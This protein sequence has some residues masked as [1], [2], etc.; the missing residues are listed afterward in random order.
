MFIP[1]SPV[2]EEGIRRHEND[3]YLQG[4][5]GNDI[6][7][8]NVPLQQLAN[9]T[10]FLNRQVAMLKGRGGYLPANDFGTLV[11]T[12]QMLTNYA[13]AEIGITDQLM[14]FN[15][16]RVKNLFDGFVW[17][18]NNT[19]DSDPPVFEWVNDGPDIVSADLSVVNATMVDGFGRNLFEVLGVST[20]QEAMIELQ[21]RC[22]NNA[23]IDNSK[24][25][26][27]GDLMIGDYIDGLDLS[28]AAPHN[29]GDAPQAWNETYKN[30]RIVIAG[31]NTYKRVGDTGNGN[32][33]N[34]ILFTFRNNCFRSR[35][36]A[37][38][39][40]TGGYA[41]SELRT[42]LEGATGDGSGAF[43]VALKAQLGNVLYTIKKAHSKKSSYAWN[44][45]TVFI[46]SEI[47]IF[48]CPYWGDEGTYMQA[49]TSPV[50]PERVGYTTNVHFP[51]FQNGYEYRMRLWNGAR[52]WS[53]LSTP[54]AHSGAYFCGVSSS[55]YSSANGAS[56]SGGVAPAFCVA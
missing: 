11:P 36:N 48:G 21:R 27:F 34:H 38:N 18:L 1:E 5:I 12:Q 17:V 51:I 41:A 33:K 15:N 25:P 23:E 37:A 19:P 30:N 7:P 4:A 3:D 31:F 22:N 52:Q 20:I 24:I 26:D 56:S 55:G 32:E 13:L 43:A 46:P 45:Y 49:L 35:M 10:V 28:G 53:W 47:E 29:N 40:N 50:I 9:R 6:G 44:N 16:T 14:I 8:D 42:Y 2:W 54:A 39:D